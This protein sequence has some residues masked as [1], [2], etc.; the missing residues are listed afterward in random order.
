MPRHIDGQLCLDMRLV[1]GRDLAEAKDGPVDRAVSMVAQAAGAL[2]VAY[3]DNLIRNLSRWVRPV[4]VRQLVSG[5]L[6][7]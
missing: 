5:L 3:A 7:R 4:G 2:D 6:V 1:R